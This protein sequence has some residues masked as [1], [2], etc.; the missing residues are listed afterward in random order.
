MTQEKISLSDLPGVL[1][2][3]RPG[4]EVDCAGELKSVAEDAGILI[5]PHVEPGSGYV[6]SGPMESHAHATLRAELT[7]ENL[8][9][10]RQLL[11]GVFATGSLPAEDRVSPVMHI[12]ETKVLPHAG[13]RGFGTIMVDHGDSDS[14]RELSKFCDAL[15]R[16]MS[17]AFKRAN[18]LEKPTPGH[19]VPKLHLFLINAG[20]GFVGFSDLNAAAPWPLGIPRL[21][22][23][24]GS[25]SRSV[26]KLEEAFLTFLS[27]ADREQHLRD[28][29]RAVD[30]GAAPGGWTW[31]L[32]QCRMF[33]TAVDNGPMDAALLTTGMVDHVQSDAFKYV[34]RHA[35]DWLVCDVVEQPARIAALIADWIEKGLT[36]KA[37]F[38]LKL[39]MKNC[40]REVLDCLEVVAK[41][42]SRQGLRVH[43]K[44]L[45]HDR[46]EVTV[47]VIP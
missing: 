1:L 8:I 20:H 17:N 42:A 13:S 30:L 5:T 40:L 39:P 44:Q 33:V 22:F 16:P 43:A 46:R 4:F 25:P 28:G 19:A 3:C 6:F 36:R 11:F 9:F 14:G 37:I 21:K 18:L 10:A 26:L 47:I 15:T 2:Y 7:W 27:P 32:V 23:P 12:A 41:S 45:Y 34:P 24:S 35:V 31:Y 38:N 29:M